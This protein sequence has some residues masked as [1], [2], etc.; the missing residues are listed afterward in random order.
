M[1]GFYHLEAN[2]HASVLLLQIVCPVCREPLPSDLE[3]SAFQPESGA[4]MLEERF[5]P[6][7]EMREQQRSMTDLF[8]KQKQK[9][10]IIDL[11]EERNKYLLPKVS[12]I[13]TEVTG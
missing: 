6:S 4:D 3:L 9:G 7:E 11:D 1:E 13:L 5:S 10:G 8:E 2:C 12:H